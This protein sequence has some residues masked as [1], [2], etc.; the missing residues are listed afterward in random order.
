MKGAQR[1]YFITIAD[2]L[3]NSCLEVSRY[4]SFFGRGETGT[5]VWKLRLEVT[6]DSCDSPSIPEK[7][8][9]KANDVNKFPSVGLP[10][11]T[12]EVMFFEAELE[13]SNCPLSFS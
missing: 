9:R 2:F 7:T 4:F 8:Y 11:F 6:S 3:C 12:H 13:K 5:E 1:S 10:C